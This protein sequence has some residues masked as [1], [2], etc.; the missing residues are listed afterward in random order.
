[1][2]LQINILLLQSKRLKPSSQWSS[3]EMNTISAI[4]M[5]L[6][7]SLDQEDKSR[8]KKWRPYN[9][10]STSVHRELATTPAVL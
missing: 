10:S 4:S 2:I 1:M 3:L 6:T 5:T 7:T 8:V 9:C